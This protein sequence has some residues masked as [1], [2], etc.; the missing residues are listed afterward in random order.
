MAIG[1]IHKGHISDAVVRRMK[2]RADAGV[3]DGLSMSPYFL[4]CRHYCENTQAMLIFTRDVGMHSSGWWKNPDYERC[5]HL[6][7]S[8]EVAGVPLPQN[9]KDARRWCE[10]FF[11]G[12]T[13]LLWIEPPYSP[14]GKQR[15]VYHYRLFCDEGWQPIKPRGEV[16]SREWTPADWKSWSDVHDATETDR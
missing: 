16:Y 5:Y 15:E 9:H 7:I 8:F 12:D 1:I 10:A 14:E 13:K 6:S 2:A 3:F 4:R 11:G